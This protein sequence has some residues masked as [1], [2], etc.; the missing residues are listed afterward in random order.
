MYVTQ[1]KDAG[2]GLRVTM[3]ERAGR[4]GLPPRVRAM[5]ISRPWG[6]VHFV[7]SQKRSLAGR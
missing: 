6:L 3:K 1:G 5:K 4:C 2:S 7:E